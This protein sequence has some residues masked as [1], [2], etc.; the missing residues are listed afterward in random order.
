MWTNLEV[1]L[2]PSFMIAVFCFSV[3]WYVYS[4][5]AHKK[6]TK[7]VGKFVKEFGYS[8][9]NDSDCPEWLIR[10]D[11]VY[12]AQLSRCR[13]KN[14]AKYK[15]YGGRGISVQ[16]SAIEFFHWFKKNKP[17]SLAGMSVGRLDHSKSYSFDNIVFQSI[18][19]NSRERVNRSPNFIKKPV[20]ELCS[21]N[22]LVLKRYE[23]VN[24]AAKKN[25]LTPGAIGHLVIVRI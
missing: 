21:K 5:M 24:E 3:L 17:K 22:H 4:T 1:S 8:P 18:R 10:A 15:N 11:R 6:G 13:N 14:N 23:S 12:R 2:Q 25:K 20:L 16:Y 7:L 19:D 9:Q